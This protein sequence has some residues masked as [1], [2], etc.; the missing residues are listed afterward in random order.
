M[1]AEGQ[2]IPPPVPPELET[3]LPEIVL[4]RIASSLGAPEDSVAIPPPR[5]F[6]SVSTRNEQGSFLTAIRL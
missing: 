5:G 6:V 3:V 2:E 1:R 4:A